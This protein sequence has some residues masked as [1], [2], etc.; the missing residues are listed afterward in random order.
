MN[1]VNLTGRLTRVPELVQA[2]TATE[3]ATLRIAVRRRGRE[4]AVFCDVKTFGKQ[5]VACVEHLDKGRL[6]A[7]EGRLE[8]DEWVGS[9]GSKHSRLYVIGERVEFIDRRTDEPAQAV[10]EA[11]AADAGPEPVAQAA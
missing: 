6:I 9:D 4:G 1:T 3:I 2:R 8:L 7:V 5:A 10:A 11:P